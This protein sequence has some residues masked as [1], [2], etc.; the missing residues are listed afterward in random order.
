MAAP[1]EGPQ[2]HGDLRTRRRRRCGLCTLVIT[3]VRHA[4]VLDAPASRVAGLTNGA[5]SRETG[6]GRPNSDTEAR[7]SG[8]SGGLEDGARQ[9]PLRLA[10]DA[11]PRPWSHTRDSAWT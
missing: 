10:D 3:I 1:A 4:P 11:G 7:R 5:A 2:L 6:G 9:N 8:A